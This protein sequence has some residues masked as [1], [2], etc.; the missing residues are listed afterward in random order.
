MPDGPLSL[1]PNLCLM[2]SAWEVGSQR[3]SEIRIVRSLLCP[4]TR[5]LFPRP[6]LRA[7]TPR[8]YSR[9]ASNSPPSTRPPAKA[10]RGG[11]PWQRKPAQSRACLAARL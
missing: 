11:R 9:A 2:I 8:I 4:M 6:T 3:R 1:S 5:T 10:T 7:R